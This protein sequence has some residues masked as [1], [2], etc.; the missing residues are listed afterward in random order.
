MKKIKIYTYSHNR[1]D[2]IEIQYNTI[3]RHVKDDFEF[4][5]FN[6]ER[7]G[8]DGGFDESKIG[9]ISSI[10]EKLNIEC[11]KVE[12]DPELQY[13]NGEKMFEE[14]RYL[15]GN[16]ACAY[17]YTWGWKN[18]ICNNDCLSVI[19]DS[20]MFLIKDVSFIKMME[21]YNF[22]Y[23]PSYRYNEKYVKNIS[24]SVRRFLSDG[25]KKQIWSKKEYN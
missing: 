6:N 21:G 10:C 22:S 17:S 9:E 23:V 4:I 16:I 24:Y 13:M 15:N 2:F 14:D 19:L 8:G 12:L 20:D 1:P 3:K 5:V 11:I 7:P 25:Y 18:Y